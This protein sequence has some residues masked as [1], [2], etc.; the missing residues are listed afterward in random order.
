MDQS[1][2]LIAAGWIMQNHGKIVILNGTSSSGKTSIVKALQDLLDEPYLDAGID[3]FIWMLPERYLDRPLWDE[4]LG[5]ATQA[6]EVGDRLM[7][8]MHQA[9]AALSRMGNN[10]VADH[11]LVEP[12]WL[13]ECVALF[14]D[15]PAFLVAVRCPLEVLEQRERARKN[16]TWGQA[17][18]QLGL[19]HAHGIYDLEVDTSISSA[20]E[21]ALQIKARL[22]DGNPPTAFQRLG[23]RQFPNSKLY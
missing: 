16:R 4:V 7:S 18:A 9:I 3:K 1:H 5:L 11:V 17:R 23:R 6:G 10:V 19:V 20:Q 14:S 12:R 15:L 22:Q 2:S 8:G 13:Q 21:C